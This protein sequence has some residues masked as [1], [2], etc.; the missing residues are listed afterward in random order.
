MGATAKEPIETAFGEVVGLIRVARQCAARLVN[1][2]VTDL[3]WRIGRYLHH[4][5]EADGWAKGTVV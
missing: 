2:E 5:I 4:K 3:Y 1:T